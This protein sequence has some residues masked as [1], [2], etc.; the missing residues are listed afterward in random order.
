MLD[1]TISLSLRQL[2]IINLYRL[3][4]DLKLKRIDTL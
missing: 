1:R 3:V 2:M 4:D